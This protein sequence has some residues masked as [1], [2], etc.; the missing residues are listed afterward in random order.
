MAILLGRFPEPRLNRDSVELLDHGN[1]DLSI[2]VA[3]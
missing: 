2:G 1:P 3:L